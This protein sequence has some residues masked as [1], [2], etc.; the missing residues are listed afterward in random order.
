MA[1]QNIYLY[2]TQYPPCKSSQ[3]FMKP[4]NVGLR[5]SLILSIFG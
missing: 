4:A 2:A 5:K 3:I 1:E